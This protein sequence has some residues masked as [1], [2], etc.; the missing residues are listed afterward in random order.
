MGKVKIDFQDF[1]KRGR[2]VRSEL[3]GGVVYL[4]DGQRHDRG[5]VRLTNIKCERCGCACADQDAD[6]PRP[7]LCEQ[8]FNKFVSRA[9][10]NVPEQ[11][12]R[13]RARGHV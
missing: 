13:D 4:L 8:C 1:V 9:A 2:L 5:T 12:L 11:V 6:F 3:G 7:D 10:K